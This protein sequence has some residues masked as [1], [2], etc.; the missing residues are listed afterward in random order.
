MRCFWWTND[1]ADDARDAY[2]LCR[3]NG[4][5]KAEEGDW[6]VKSLVAVIAPGAD[7]M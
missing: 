1:H 4:T 3:P 2:T 5:P 6:S 7:A